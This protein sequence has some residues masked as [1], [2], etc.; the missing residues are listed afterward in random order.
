MGE[1]AANVPPHGLPSPWVERFLT[2]I[3]ESG[4][5]LDLACGSGRHARLLA[6]AG[7]GVLAVD[8]DPLALAS[9]ADLPGVET[10]L[11]DLEGAD[12]PLTGQR[13]AGIVVTNYLWRPRLAD[14]ALLLQPG[15]VLIYETFMVGNERYGKPANPEF[16]LRS[17]ELLA[18]A[19][20]RGMKVVAYEEGFCDWPKPALRQALCALQP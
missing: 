9:L 10:R 4:P 6:A 8:R 15:G 19:L 14:L 18:F 20:G 13:F 1:S 7:H 2:L 5:T 12:W 3:P 16:L 11:L 17:Q